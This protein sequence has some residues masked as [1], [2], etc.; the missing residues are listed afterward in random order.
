MSAYQK[1]DL[2]DTVSRFFSK[3]L[4]H[5]DE[6]ER[7]SVQLQDLVGRIEAGIAYCKRQKE[8]YPRIQQYSDKISVLNATKNYVCG[9]IGLDLLEE[10]MRIYPKWDKDP[11]DEDTKAL[12]YEARALKGGS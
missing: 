6:S 12:I 8:M 9:N 10:Y 4:H 5:T 1:G 11:E 3:S 2:G 7:I